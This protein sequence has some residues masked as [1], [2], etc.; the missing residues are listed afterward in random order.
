MVW[1][2]PDGTDSVNVADFNYNA[3]TIDEALHNAGGG[4]E[5]LVT[6]TLN[7]ETGEVINSTKTYEEIEDAV[8]TGKYV[9][10]VVVNSS[11]EGL[12]YLNFVVL[13]NYDF[14]YLIFSTTYAISES[15][16]MTET[17]IHQQ[18]GTI[19]AV[20]NTVENGE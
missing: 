11:G 19:Q 6:Y 12:S 7:D 5:F 14:Y 2:K 16:L 15:V 3:D 10:A 9:R 20:I 8:L 17:L 18:D 4:S 1:K 13:H